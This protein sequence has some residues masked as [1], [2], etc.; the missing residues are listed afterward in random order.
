M[1]GNEA[2]FSGTVLPGNL[3]ETAKLTTQ[4]FRVLCST[5][6]AC[7]PNGVHIARCSVPTYLSHPASASFLL[8]YLFHPNST[9][10]IVTYLA[11]CHHN[12]PYLFQATVQ[13]SLSSCHTSFIHHLFHPT[14]PLSFHHISFIPTHLFLRPLFEQS[15]L[16]GSHGLLEHRP[17]P[18]Y[19][20]QPV[21][22]RRRN[23]SPLPLPIS[24]YRCFSSS[25]SFLPPLEGSPSRILSATS[26]PCS[27]GI[28][29]SFCL[30][31]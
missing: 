23:A 15:L 21:L 25:R 10:F 28:R 19:R 8:P 27:S 5:T 16:R 14:L 2:L 29:G 9:F 31:L 18:L 12:A 1:A 6:R 17:L 11:S 24:P 30:C 22:P 4:Y 20:H 3:F 26:T 7:S 13:I